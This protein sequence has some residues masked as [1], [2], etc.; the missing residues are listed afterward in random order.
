MRNDTRYILEAARSLGAC[1]L[2]DGAHGWEGLRRLL[3]SPQGREFCTAR[4]F[5]PAD[6][7]ARIARSMPPAG[8]V[9]I[10]AGEVR[11]EGQHDVCVALGTAATVVCRG[12]EAVHRVI[13]AHGARVRVVARDHAV[14]L[15]CRIGH[16]EVTVEKDET[17][18]IL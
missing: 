7:W 6:M 10:D 13:A 1:A 4:A 15:V 2:A 9:F 14:V 18:I 5:P 17:A 11:V 3:F 12:T 8:G 16:P